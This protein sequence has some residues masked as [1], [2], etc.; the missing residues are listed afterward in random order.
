M[1]KWIYLSLATAIFVA[2]FGAWQLGFFAKNF[3]DI[4]GKTI[5]SVAL[6]DLYGNSKSFN[7]LENSETVIYFFAS[8]CAPCFKTLKQLQT[9]NNKSQ[10]KINLLAVALDKDIDGVKNMIRRANYSGD[11]WLVKEGTTALQQKW[12][13]NEKRA[14]PYVIK[15]NQETEILESSY[16]IKSDED[17]LSVLVNGSSLNARDGL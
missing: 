8:W 14:V 2:I 11:V 3:D 9:L 15:L 4:K 12:F 7:E 16:T 5:Q 6:Q 1:K 10:F 17:W 13:G